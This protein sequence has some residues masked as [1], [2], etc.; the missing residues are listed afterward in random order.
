MA[1]LVL[2]IGAP[3]SGTTWLQ[4]ILASH[5]AIV[6]PPETE[7]FSRY[8]APAVTAWDRSLDR[9]E[10]AGSPRRLKGLSTVLAADDFDAWARSLVDRTVE[11]ALATKPGAS[12]VVEKTPG[13]SLVTDVIE[14][15]APGSR[16]VH[17]VRDGRDVAASI[18]AAGAG[19]GYRWAPTTVGAAADMWREHA[20]AA[21]LGARAVGSRGFEARYEQLRDGDAEQLA[22]VFAHCGAAIDSPAAVAYLRDHAIGTPAAA[23]AS[24]I[25]VG[26]AHQGRDLDEPSGFVRQGTS[27]DWRHEWTAAQRAT[28]AS[29]AGR[30]LIEFGY[31]PDDAWVGTVSPIVRARSVAARLGS[32]GAS[33]L[34]AWAQ[35]RR[36]QL[37]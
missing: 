1:T 29:R 14:R 18:M 20:V 12:I 34:G 4:Q 22:D 9:D 30:A 7:L 17:L 15:C 16:I 32:R 11:Q 21:H 24:S 13:H 26:G 6:S 35:R 27:G 19:W 28:F 25:S 23:S 10:Q 5:P 2:L 31:E 3:R 8:L 37:P 36:E 33:R